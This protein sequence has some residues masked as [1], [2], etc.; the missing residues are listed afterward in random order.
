VL[1]F[2]DLFAG[3]GGFHLALK[4][5]GH[6][7]VFASEI[8]P[9][10]RAVYTRNFALEPAGDIRDVDAARI[11]P[12]DLVCAGF[13]CQ[14]FSKA[15][16]Q[17]G[18]ACERWG[19]L[20]EE[21]LR[22]VRHH[23]P[24]Y[25]LLEN[26][27]NLT[28]HQGGDTWRG[29]LAALEEQGYAVEARRLSA[30]DLG[31]PQTRE[32][33][34][35]VGSRG[36]LP[37]VVWPEPV[38]NGEADSLDLLLDDDPPDARW[39]TR[40][41]VTCL[42][43]WQAFLEAWPH[44]EPLPSFPIWAGE[45]GATYPY[46]EATPHALG[47]AALGDYRGYLGA[48][49][50]PL[51][52][53]ARFE[54]L[55]SYARAPE[56]RFPRWKIRFIRQNRDLYAAHR[57]W[58]DPW[59]TR[60]AAFPPSWQKLEWNAG[61]M[62][63]EVWAGIL[64]FRAS[65]VRVK[66]PTRAPTLVAMTST[67]VP[68]VGWRRRYLTPRECARLQ[69]M[70]DLVHLPPSAERAFKAL[71]NAVNVDLVERIARDLHAPAPVVSSPTLPVS[72]RQASAPHPAPATAR[73]RPAYPSDLMATFADASRVN[74]RPGVSMLSVLRHLKYEPWYALAEFVD[75]ALQ[76]FLRHKKDIQAVDGRGASC[77]VRI[78]LDPADGGRIVVRDDAAGI[79]RT[80]YA[81][82]FRAAEVPPDN[83]GL[84]EFGMG[85]KSAAC[86]FAP[87]WTVRTSA[88]GEATEKTVT[89]DIRSIVRDSL[90]ELEVRTRRAPS[91]DH[92]TEITLL[93]LHKI[94]QTRTIAKIR[95]H[96]ASIYR[97]FLQDGT[98]HLYL[99]DE[100]LTYETPAVLVAPLYD[101]PNGRVREWSKEIDLQL[102]SRKRIRG[103]AALRETGSTSEAGFALFRRR[104]LIVGSADEGYRPEQIFGRS[105]SFVY[106]RLFGELH[107]DGFEVTHTKDG[108]RWEDDEEELLDLL[109]KELDAKPLSLIQQARNYRSKPRREELV[110]AAEKAVNR[111]AA[112]L[113]REAPGALATLD[114]PSK[115]TDAPPTLPP[116]RSAAAR[117]IE[118]DFED[119]RWRVHLELTDD[120]AVGPWLDLA[121]Q[122]TPAAA[123]GRQGAVREIRVRLALAHPFTAR[124]AGA[125]EEQ[126]EPLLRIAAGLALAETLA[127][128]GGARMAGTVRGYL[129]DILREALSKA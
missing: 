52:P 128:A 54:A 91:D 62:R 22:V 21:V 58:L 17:L 44:D 3:L 60:I 10:L 122:A 69:S 98:L 49:L 88:L 73:G 105:N 5:L 18:V 33:V 71:G 93:N 6:E 36:S 115:A 126:I 79:H 41:A 120:P 56:P 29:M 110:G 9:E 75:N 48:P 68:V 90:E 121:D 112:V 96:L 76:S 24:A 118:F 106:Q 113:E 30:L 67:Q 99:N 100:S 83:T 119:A 45:F 116:A 7:C 87:R 37:G 81:R 38:S 31:V 66:R 92:F 74:I 86:W 26:V 95:R 85:M 84:S 57:A 51:A 53:E 11:P 43:T 23:R 117:A 108:F 25:L 78:T 19:D 109:R 46:E 104:R 97:C 63:R 127:R 14:P 42:E 72:R 123:R 77:T 12:H 50:A 70:D 13:P 80:D 114:P 28:R 27:P 2:V 40:R 124:F 16:A 129:N 39:L 1:R 64:Q 82:A 103:F 47:A 94:P 15:G 34:F 107:L 111:T 61:D 102:T 89:F 59:R 125:D 35:I 20:Y 101:S 55:P 8:D 65:G 4:R 32:R